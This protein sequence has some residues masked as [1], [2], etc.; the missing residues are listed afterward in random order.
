MAFL[1]VCPFADCNQK[2]FLQ[3]EWLLQHLI[4][5]H[6]AFACP[7]AGCEQKTIGNDQQPHRNRMR[8][9]AKHVTGYHSSKGARCATNAKA[10]VVL[11]FFA[12][13]GQRQPA[14]NFA[15]LAQS[16]ERD[17]DAKECANEDGEKK[18]STQQVDGSDEEIQQ[19]EKNAKNRKKRRKIVR[20]MESDDEHQPNASFPSRVM[21]ERSRFVAMATVGMGGKFIK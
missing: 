17:D 7:I 9:V 3:Y 16:D 10:R 2:A 8:M 15:S 5:G 20:Q 19:T 11:D 18:D 21:I 14:E 6:Y 4:A 13:L 12:S 1:F